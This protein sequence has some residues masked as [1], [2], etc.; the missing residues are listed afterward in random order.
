MLLLSR[1][2]CFYEVEVNIYPLPRTFLPWTIHYEVVQAKGVF[3]RECGEITTFEFS[4][5]R[6]KV[7]CVNEVVAVTNVLLTF[8]NPT[9]HDA[10]EKNDKGNTGMMIHNIDASPSKRIL[11]PHL[12]GIIIN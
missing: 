12:P 10:L 7:Q 6:C 4:T 1:K 9:I 8:L 5:D 2:V 11:S 3:Y